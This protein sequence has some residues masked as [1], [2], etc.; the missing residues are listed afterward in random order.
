MVAFLLINLNL[1]IKYPYGF[2]DIVNIFLFPN[3]PPSASSEAALVVKRWDMA[4]E[5]ITLT[6]YADTAY[7]LQHQ[8]VTPIVVW[9]SFKIMLEQ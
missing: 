8:K 6:T 3:L 9:E 5:R 7:L 1:N 4:L 2:R